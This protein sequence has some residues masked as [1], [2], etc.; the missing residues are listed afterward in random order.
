MVTDLTLHPGGLL[1]L[2]HTL[3]NDGG[4]DYAVQEL[5]AVLPVGADDTEILD[6]TGRWCRERHP[7]RHALRQGTWVRSGRHGRTGHDSSLLL[8][9]GTS[10]FGNRH[11]KVWAAH[12]GWSGNHEAFVDS[13]ADGRTVLG[14]SELLGSGEI[15]LAPGEVFDTPPLFAAYSDLG[16]DGISE[17]FHAWFRAR[18]RHPSMPRPVV[19]NTWEAVYFNHDLA[20]LTALA[21]TAAELG[22]ERFELD[23]GWFR[24]RCDDRAGL[25]DWYVDTE[26]WPQGLH[27]LVDALTTRDMQFGLWVEPEMINVDSDTAREHPDWIAGPASGTSHSR[28]PSEWRHQQVLDLVNPQAWQYICDRIHALL[29]EYRISYLKWDQN[30][31]LLEVGHAGRPSGHEQT[32]AAYR[33][34]DA[35]RPRTPKLKSRAALPAA[36]ALTWESCKELTASGLRT[37][38]TRWNARPSSAGPSRWYPLSWW[39]RILAP[40]PRTPLPALT[41]CPSVPSLPSSDI[42]A[43]NGI[44]GPSPGRSGRNCAPSSYCTKSSGP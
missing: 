3:A 41:S 33:L 8:S 28:L 42:L 36:P 24:Q 22:V 40:P 7:Q 25:G 14:A 19:L 1:E 32:L 38:T 44:F 10:G 4:T 17:E 34:F 27:P 35:L 5:S 9:V 31:D 30:R 12:F 11:C 26:V 6:L 15:V 2:R 23:D 29:T 18:A 16:L 37:A 39:V 20:A 21:E 13:A 43:W